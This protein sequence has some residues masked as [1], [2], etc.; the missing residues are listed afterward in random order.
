MFRRFF[1]TAGAMLLGL[2][3]VSA[4]QAPGDKADPGQEMLPLLA[5]YP[6]PLRQAILELSVH[7]ALLAKLEKREAKAPL[8]PLVAG[9]SKEVQQAAASVAKYPDILKVLQ[10]NA[11]ATAALGKLYAKNK[12][13]VNEQLDQEAA[14]ESKATD[15]WANRL[16]Q[17]GDALEQLAPAIQ[18]YQKQL[19]G[20]VSAEDAANYAGVNLAANNVNVTA[21]PTPGFINFAISNADAYPALANTMVSQWLG[22]RNSA[23]Y[24]R[25]FSSWWGRYQNHFHDEHMLRGDENRA[26]R[27]GE[28]AR[29]D[30]NFAKDDHR[31]DKFQ[32]HRK[33]FPHLGKVNP[34]P[35]DHKPEPGKKPNVKDSE[36]KPVHR[37]QPGK[38]PMVHRAQ[39]SAH[40]Q[41]HHAAA[42]H[43]GGGGHGG[44]RR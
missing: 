39:P 32:D 20:S 3:L 34:P 2:C 38:H 33:D 15:E 9:L 37:P 17:D 1:C 23:A 6:K 28:M 29:Y 5:A 13:K 30:R 4:E 16:G 26:N 40:H 11:P 21:L 25:T 10:E 43:H 18:A 41:V 42:A 12:D 36:H 27:L 22:S 19:G 14:A 44:H 35:R 31:W 8:E 24:D 7:P